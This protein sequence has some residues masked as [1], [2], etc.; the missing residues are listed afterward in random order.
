M[1][2]ALLLCA[3]AAAIAAPLGNETMINDQ[4]V[5]DAI[6]WPQCAKVITDIRD[7]SNCGC[8]WAFAG[9][10]AASDRL[11]ISTNASIMVPLSAQDVCFCSSMDGCGGGQI[12]TPWSHIA[13]A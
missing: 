6:N 13:S 11:C 10:S 7:Q 1:K 4:R 8:C 9:T 5:V 2:I 3:V 12:T